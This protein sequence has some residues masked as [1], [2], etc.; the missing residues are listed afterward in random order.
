MGSK[1]VASFGI[2][3]LHA[4]RSPPTDTIECA[5]PGEHTNVAAANP[6]ILMKLVTRLNELYPTVFNP[7]R[8]GGDKDKAA[9]TARARG[10]YWGPFVFP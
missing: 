2:R 9:N 8:G 10:G 3:R 7:Q 5:D 1:V 4:L 6:A